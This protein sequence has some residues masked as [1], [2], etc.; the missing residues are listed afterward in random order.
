MKTLSKLLSDNRSLTGSLRILTGGTYS[1]KRAIY[2]SGTPEGLR[3]LAKLLEAQADAPDNDFSKLER[4][5]GALFFA[6]ADSVDIFEL[7]SS[8]HPPEKHPPTLD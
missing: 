4:S 2:I 1:G 8:S 3:F 7:H 5:S 6:T